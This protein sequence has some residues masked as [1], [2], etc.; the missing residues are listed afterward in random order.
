MPR[1]TI[2]RTDPFWDLDGRA[3]R[4]ERTRHRIVAGLAF[5][6]A[7]GACGLTAATW[8]LLLEPTVS[9]LLGI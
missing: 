5:A 4:R 2:R 7:V 1:L 8:A 6:L 3:V 9:R